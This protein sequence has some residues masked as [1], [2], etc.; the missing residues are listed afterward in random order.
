MT[1]NGNRCDWKTALSMKLA[2]VGATGGIGRQLLKQARAEGHDVT[3]LVRHPN[4]MPAG[5]HVV[6][7]DLATAE[8]AALKSAMIGFDS[9]LS[10]LG[11]RPLSEAGVVSHGTR[12]IVETMRA[13]GVRRIVVVS[14]APIST[15]ASAGCPNPPRYDPGEGF[16]MR[17]LLTPLLRAVLRKSYADLAVMEDILRE[18]DRD[19]TVVRPTRLTN[20]PLSGAYRVAHGRNVRRGLTISRADVARFM[21]QALPRSDTIEQAIGIAY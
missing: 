14:A 19:W 3:A 17:H 15:V 4:G 1:R 12:A 8:P 11:P 7:T 21:L 6:Q 9:V 2:I 5:V 20:K 10:A 18:S 16:F 13:I